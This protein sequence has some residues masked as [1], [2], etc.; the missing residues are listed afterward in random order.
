MPSDKIL[1]L[2]IGA[3][4]GEGQNGYRGLVRQCEGRSRWFDVFVGGRRTLL[5][6]P[7]CAHETEA[8]ARQRPD[9]AL[10]VATVADRVPRDIEASGQRRIRDDAPLPDGADEI[11]LAN[12]ALSVADQEIEKIENLRR[13]RNHI[14][15]AT[16]L[17]PISVEQAI[18]EEIAQVAVPSS[19]INPSRGTVARARRR[20]IR[21]LLGKCE[22]LV[23]QARPHLGILVSDN[24][25]EQPPMT[26]ATAT[27]PQGYVLDA[28]GGER[29]VHFRNPGNMFIKVDPVKGAS[30]H[31][32][33]TQQ[34]PAGA[35]IPIHRHFQMDE[36]FY[37]LEGSG[38]FILNDEHHPFEKGATIFIPRNTW[39]GFANP[40][41]ELLLLWVVTPAGLEG[42]FR[43]TCNPPGALRKQLTGEQVN[44][45]ARKYGTEFR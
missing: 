3:Q 11:I 17:A 13:D 26:Q 28:T 19:G 16:Q 42:Y 39:H 38:I 4:V 2:G 40:D 31:A 36:V 21:P 34:V 43:E 7:H 41:Q 44:E 29:L 22:L 27:V 30:K 6:L 35:G 12:N 10:V 25:A 45:I 9:Q 20:K 18:L 23:K 14:F 1:L 8:L 5:L 37:V 24:D 33:G 32:L 15:T